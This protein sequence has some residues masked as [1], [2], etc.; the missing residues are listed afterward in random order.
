MLRHVVGDV[1]FFEIL[2]TYYSSEQH[3]FRNAKTEDFQKICEQVSGINLEKF[4]HQWVYEE[5][6]PHYVVDWNW[7]QNGLG[8]E[9]QLE[10]KQD[11]DNYLFWMPID[12]TI[13]TLDGERTFV[14]WDSLQSQTFVLEVTSE[15]LS[16]EIDK[17]NWI[18]KDVQE[19]LVNPTFDQ[20][21]LLVNGVNFDVY[22]SSIVAA[23]ENKAFWGD[24]PISF[25]DCFLPPDLG[26]PSTLPEPKGHGRVPANVLGKYSTVIWIGNN[27]QGDISAWFQTS[28][29]SFLKAGGNLFL[30]TRHGQEFIDEDKRDYLGIEWAESSMNTLGNCMSEYPGLVSMT[31]TDIQSSNAVFD[32]KFY[33]DQSILLFKETTSFLED[34]AIGVWKKPKSGGTYRN[35]GGQFVF[36]SCR[37]YRLINQDLRQNSEY[38]L[39]NFFGESK[40]SDIAEQNDL[41]SS[42]KRYKLYKNYPNP[43][44]PSTKIKYELPMMNYVELNIYNLPGQKVKTLVSESQNAGFHQVEWDGSHF[45][46]GI[47]YYRLKAGN[48]ENVKK[49]ILIK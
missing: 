15:P 10:I 46:S 5:Y 25:W 39:E 8:Y 44:N 28:V 37:P 48:F 6:Y 43:F 23:Y 7:L 19:K 17:N 30:I 16:V 9:V 32:T 12:V 11:Q 38:I 14:V 45:P 24:F 29:L 4:F 36:I 34:R 13:M 27:Y 26:Y 40:I 33:D 49:M 42:L 47:Y 31:F 18:L 22:G 21:I 35:K 20:G 41:S 1:I 2:K 3:Q